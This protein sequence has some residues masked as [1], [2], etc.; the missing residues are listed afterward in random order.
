MTLNRFI[1]MN[2][3]QLRVENNIDSNSVSAS[4]GRAD[5]IGGQ[6]G[7]SLKQCR[8]N[9]GA[10]ADLT[11]ATLFAGRLR[12]IGLPD[13]KPDVLRSRRNND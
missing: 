3:L 10:T 7:R 1:A 6:A 5:Q 2:I 8:L 13:F 9:P 4:V 11:V 12:D